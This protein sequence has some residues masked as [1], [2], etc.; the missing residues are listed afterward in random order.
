MAPCHAL[1][2]PPARRRH[3]VGRGRRTGRDRA[4]V[5]HRQDAI[6][7]GQADGGVITAIRLL[8]PFAARY[9]RGLTL[10][11]IAMGGEILT[12]V[13]APIPIQ[14]A[15]DQVIRPILASRLQVGPPEVLILAALPLL[16][17]AFALL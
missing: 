13:L 9:W 14:R 4:D 15:I 11:L 10:A 7:R 6:R 1:R 16:A 5:G 12:A 2:G 8:F 17:V 3:D